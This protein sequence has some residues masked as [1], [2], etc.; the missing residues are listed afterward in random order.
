MQ[1]KE[2]PDTLIQFLDFLKNNGISK[3]EYQKY[4]GDFFEL[5]SRQKGIPFH[6]TFELTPLCNLDCKMC[7]VH[8][9]NSQFASDNLLS[10][11]TFKKII[12]EAYD[13][14]MRKASVTGGE[15]LTHPC[16]EEI[17]L[18]LFK[19]GVRTN[20]FSNGVLLNEQ[21]IDFFKKYRPKSIQVTL[22]GSNNDAYKKV[23]GKRV[24]DIVKE[25]IQ[26]LRNAGL[27]IRLSITPSAFMREDIINTLD[28][29]YQLKVPFNINAS[30]F[31]ARE[32][33]GRQIEDLSVDEYIEVYKKRNE[34][35]HYNETDTI[36]LK[37]LP[38]PGISSNNS[39]GLKCG[40]GRSSFV[41]KYDGTMSPC[42]SLYD[43]ISYPL[44]YGFE[45]AWKKINIE[46][47]EYIR[48]TECVDCFYSSVCL[49]CVAF[50]KKAPAGHC[51]RRIC[52]RT[53]KMVS[54]G[55]LPNPGKL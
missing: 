2:V 43:I 35:R 39:K 11:N 14:G 48:P 53:M 5:S 40:A 36:D 13:C 26:N 15:C 45:K 12:D 22:Y 24:F 37:E 42:L 19:K 47:N 34:L 49:K 41:I 16:F 7:Y 33:T 44:E 21:K 25:N 30:L 52:Q 20:I 9:S 46:V 23:T 32:N 29:A 50:H 18:Y 4:I 3:D 31:E 54:A 6:G 10:A 51:D 1:I 8:L 17:Y 38:D 28:L 27:P 55:V